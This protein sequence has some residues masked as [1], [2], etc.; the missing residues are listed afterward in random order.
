MSAYGDY[1]FFVEEIGNP[2]R[3]VVDYCALNRITKR[4]NAPL[5]KYD[6]MFGLLGDAKCGNMV[7]TLV[8]IF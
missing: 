5:P 2:L 8:S 7:L 6:A 1:L 3:G 4:N